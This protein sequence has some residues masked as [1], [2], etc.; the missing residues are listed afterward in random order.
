MEK[1]NIEIW[2]CLFWVPLFSP[3]VSKW[4]QLQWPS[5]ISRTSGNMKLVA[6]AQDWFKQYFI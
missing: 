2:R 1:L 6:I 5:L 4:D 3:T